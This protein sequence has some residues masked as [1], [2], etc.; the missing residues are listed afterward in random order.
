MED[1]IDVSGIEEWE[2]LAAL[3][4]NALPLG[5]GRLIYDHRPLTK[6]QALDALGQ[7]RFESGWRVDYLGGRPLKIEVRD[8]MLFGARLYDRD[9]GMGACRRVVDGL[10]ARG[11][12]IGGD[13]AR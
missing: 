12:S 5:M 13:A 8:G 3:Y 1:F 4:D 6:E 10:R 2:L 9:Q 11:R 7:L